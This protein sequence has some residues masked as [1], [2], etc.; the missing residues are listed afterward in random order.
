MQHARSRRPS[1]GP[2]LIA[3]LA[4]LVSAL[5]LTAG[6]AAAGSCAGAGS[7]ARA[8]STT[9]ATRTDC[10]TGTTTSAGTTTGTSAV[11]VGS[12]SYSY[13]TITGD[14]DDLDFAWA[15]V[16]P[17]G[18]RGRETFGTTDQRAS[19]LI[20]QELRAK[21][22]RFL[23]VRVDERDYVVRDPALLARADEIVE[24]MAEL[25]RRMGELGA[26]Q[27][28]LGAQ[29]GRLGGEQGRLGARQGVIASK[30]ARLAVRS[31][32]NDADDD[33]EVRRIERELAA[34]ERALG[35]EMARLGERQAELGE[36]QAELGREQ[37]R[38]GKQM[39]KISQDTATQI[40]ALMRDAIRDGR[41]VEIRGERSET[42]L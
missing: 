6:N 16:K 12:R 35:R 32:V 19:H 27:G 1:G 21:R 4:G 7:C 8:T 10:A 13:G 5:L 11:P 37:G 14:D 39:S 25:G 36:R 18:D 34:E 23:Y 9:T 33:A 22:G 42:S 41:A 15:L 29:Q 38:Y 26:R 30:R 24:P 40:R 3:G 31:A 20:E 2:I 17:D 28:S